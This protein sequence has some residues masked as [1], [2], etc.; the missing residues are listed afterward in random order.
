[1][2]PEVARIWE[3]LSADRLTIL[4]EEILATASDDNVSIEVILAKQ[5][6]RLLVGKGAAMICPIASGNPVSR[7][8]KGQFKITAVTANEQIPHRGVFLAAT[9]NILVKDVDRGR[10]PMPAGASFRPQPVALVIHISGGTTSIQAGLATRTGTTS[11]DIR[12]PVTAAQTLSRLV[13]EGTPV[14]IK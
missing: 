5:E 6:L 3:L 10:D 11:G 13:K 8:P 14:M 9:G 4:N 2:D 1:M 7:T 12:I